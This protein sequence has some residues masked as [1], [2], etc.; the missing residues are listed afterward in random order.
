MEMATHRRWL[1]PSDST[2]RNIKQ[3]EERVSETIRRARTGEARA[4]LAQ[5]LAAIGDVDPGRCVRWP[6]ST[7]GGSGGRYPQVKWRGQVV[8]VT[9]Y[10]FEQ[11]AGRPLTEGEVVRHSCDQPRC[12]NVWH[13]ETGSQFDN[14]QDMLTRNRQ[15]SGARNGQ[16]V[17]TAEQVRDLRQLAQEHDLRGNVNWIASVYGVS[18]TALTLVLRGETWAGVEPSVEG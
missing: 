11:V 15:A 8:R 1:S 5:H 6:F 2:E 14:V 3:Q 10:L 17:L 4:W 9:R 16:A 13:V 18:P 7:N 12:V